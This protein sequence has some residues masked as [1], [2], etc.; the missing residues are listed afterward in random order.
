M[1]DLLHTKLNIT[2]FQFF[3]VER[4]LYYQVRVKINILLNY[5]FV[6]LTPVDITENNNNTTI[7]GSGIENRINL[8][9]HYIFFVIIAFY[10]YFL[11]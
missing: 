8:K 5:V 9:K 10:S 1:I 6:K 2:A 7:Y 4:T 11:T 3:S